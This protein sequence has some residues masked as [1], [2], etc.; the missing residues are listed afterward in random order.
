MM[1]AKALTIAI[2]Y[3][4]VRSQFK[5]QKGSDGQTVERKLMDYQ[6]HRY[7]LMTNLSNAFVMNLVL[8]EMDRLYE[9]MITKIQ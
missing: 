1:L 9:K 4:F 3:S 8:R 7:K 6:T 2:R 5:N